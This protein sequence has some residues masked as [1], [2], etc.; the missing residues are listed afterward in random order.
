MFCIGFLLVEAPLFMTLKP[1][2]CCL[3]RNT[4]QPRPLLWFLLCCPRSV[5]WL[6]TQASWPTGEEDLAFEDPLEPSQRP[7]R[8]TPSVVM[9][10]G[11]RLAAS[12]NLTGTALKGQFTEKYNVLIIHSP[13]RRWIPSEE[14]VAND[15]DCITFDLDAVSPPRLQK[16]FVDSN[17]SPTPPSAQWW[18]DNE[19]IFISW[20]Q[21][22]IKYS[23]EYACEVRWSE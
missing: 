6:V 19:R 20:L 17:T 4:P 11:S 18:V 7:M 8:F 12:G 1:A 13:L 22:A 16:C 9:V 5:F 23:T 10:T 2:C 21:Q 3:I 14:T 15:F